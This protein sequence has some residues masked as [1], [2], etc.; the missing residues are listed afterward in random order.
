MKFKKTAAVVLASLMSLGMAVPA[1]AAGTYSPVIDNSLKGSITL[2]KII[3]NTGANRAHDGHVDPAVNNTPLEGIGFSYIRVAEYYSV[4]GNQGNVSTTGLYFTNI[5]QG[6]FGAGADSVASK[7]GVTVR[8]STFSNGGQTVTV[9]TVKALEDAVSAI[10]AAP[11]ANGRDPGENIT[12][13]SFRERP[14]RV[15]YFLLRQFR[16]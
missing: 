6:I 16:E 8:P 15:I 3:E 2:H 7:A 5:D 11:A 10:I 14:G 13:G 4:T 9:Y 1:M 12:A